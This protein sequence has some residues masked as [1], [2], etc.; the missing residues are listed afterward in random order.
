MLV[1]L[2]QNEITKTAGLNVIA[3]REYDIARGQYRRAVRELRNASAAERPGLRDKADRARFARNAAFKSFLFT[4]LMTILLQ[5]LARYWLKE[6]VDWAYTGFRGKPKSALQHGFEMFG[7]IVGQDPVF[8]NAWR[9]GSRLVGNAVQGKPV[10][11]ALTDLYSHPYLEAVLTMPIVA[12]E[13]ADATKDIVVGDPRAQDKI[14]QVVSDGFISGAVVSGMPTQVFGQALRAYYRAYKQNLD[15]AKA[16]VQ[17]A[18]FFPTKLALYRRRATVRLN[19]YKDLVRAAG[20]DEGAADAWWYGPENQRFVDLYRAATVSE[21]YPNGKT[22]T[23]NAPDLDAEETLTPRDRYL[24]SM[25]GRGKSRGSGSPE[26][27]PAEPTE[28]AE[29]AEYR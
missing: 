13:V 19:K 4:G 25:S 18:G 11:D 17:P 21:Q 3:N 16:E 8:G 26:A 12:F 20:G 10:K 9:G 23:P 1:T 14:V 7:S 22:L 15:G 29:P 6:L 27:A 5:A 2:F 28:P 24:R